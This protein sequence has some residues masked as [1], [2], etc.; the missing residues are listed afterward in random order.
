ME[1]DINDIYTYQEKEDVV[2]DITQ[3]SLLGRNI[4]RDKING[5]NSINSQP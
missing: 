2:I 4:T 3:N 5:N 1:N